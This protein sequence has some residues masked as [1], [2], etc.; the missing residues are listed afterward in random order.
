M[1]IFIKRFVMTTLI[2]AAILLFGVMSYNRLPVS[3]LPAI[4]FPTIQVSASLPGASPET[5]AAAVATPLEKQFTTIPGLDSMTSSSGQGRSQI[6]LQFTLDRDIDAA[7]QDVQAAISAV[8]RRL[9]RDMPSPP[10][11]QKVNPADQPVL[12]LALTSPTLPLSA[13]DEYGNTIIAPRISTI[14]GV[15]QVQVYGGQTYAVRIQ[16][17][18]RELAARG[19]GIDQVISAVQNNNVNLPTGTLW[20]PDRTVSVEADGQL[21]DAAG[22]REITVAYRNGAPVK[23]GEL[24]RVVDSV[25]NNRVAA[26]FNDSR[27]IMLAIQRQPGMNTVKVVES[28]K[29]L[30][31]LFAQQLPASVRL[32]VMVDRSESIRESVHDV[33]FSLVLALALVVMVIFVFLRNVSATIIPSMALPMSIIGTFSVMYLLGFSIDNLSLMAM[34]LATGFVVDDAVVMLENIVRHREMGKGAYQAAVDGAREVG[35]TI[36]SM[37]FSLIAVF[38]PLLF[39]G[40]IIGRLF[41]EFA[42]TISVAILVS[43]FVS[44]SLT[45]MMASRFLARSK[46]AHHGRVYWATETVYQWFLNLYKVSLASVMRHRPAAVLLSVLVLVGTVFALWKMPKGFLANDDVGFL[47]GTTEAAEG[48]SFDAMVRYQKAA[49]EIVA[50]DTNN[51]EAYMSSV[52]SGGMGGPANQGRMFIRLKPAKERRMSADEVMQALRPRLAGIPGF[53][54]F[55]SS[56]P[57]INIGGRHGV[58]QYQYTLQCPDLEVLYG[59]APKLEA[60]M[61]GMPELMDVS[62]DLRL[63]NPEA[64]VNIKRD[65]AD[66]LGISAQQIE[67]ALYSAYGSRQISTILAP[68]NQYDV[69]LEM[70]PEFQSD[71][72]ALRLLHLRSAKGGLVPL[73]AL[74][75]ITQGSGPLTINH[76]GQI[77]SVTISFNLAPGVP[78]SRGVEAI[79]KAARETLPT[80]ITPGFAGTAQAFKASMVTMP[81]LLILAILV[82]YMI[83]GILYES[84]IHPITILT[85]LPFAIFGALATLWLFNVELGLYGIVGIIMLLGVVKKNA[86]MMIDFALDAQRREGKGAQ[87]AILQ[88]CSIRF[89]PIMM[90]TLAALFATLPIALG[91]GAGATSRRPLGLAVVGGL[92]FSQIITLYV[93]PVFY[94]Y[95]D[96]LQHWLGRQ[97][98][99]GGVTQGT[100]SGGEAIPP[101]G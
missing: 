74:T 98:R 46:E 30:L 86:I 25:Q 82:V 81:V 34:T 26:W 56:P 16:L 53:K 45:P 90:T 5:M 101:A 14:E 89:R 33:K 2:M 42:V 11:Y 85:G 13:L 75:T 88:A 93:T 94:T 63:T 78:L 22:F 68:N 61:L 96:S 28:V 67:E 83:L 50:A 57:A 18:P 54:V 21:S 20:G 60:R 84:F 35:F 40:G 72:S 77:P 87:D 44:L 64:N 15:A 76:Q 71:P 41:H 12:M 97:F 43:G 27:A 1:S 80:S 92:L 17:D 7:A 52:G 6:T 8:Q 9:P 19:L 10:S 24:G 51:V 65:V 95:F 36:V 79:E 58:S 49:A 62:S 38:I 23:L 59:N 70:L 73:D 31:P 55:L 29:A 48:T 69:I 100:A 3:D 4:D 39:M 47:F 99:R 37:T 66:S 32:E 91:T